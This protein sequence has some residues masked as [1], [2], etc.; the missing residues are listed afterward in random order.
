MTVYGYKMLRSDYTSLREEG[1]VQYDPDGGWVTVPGH[2]AYVAV[3]GG[4][5]ADG[6][7]PVIVRMECRSQVPHNEFGLPYGVQCFRRVRIVHVLEP[8]EPVVWPDGLQEWYYDG[9]LHHTTGPAVIYAD[10]TQEWYYGNLLHR[11]DGPAVIR[12]DGTKEWYRRGVLHRADGPAVIRPDGTKEWHR[13][14]A[15]HRAGG[16]ALVLADGTR[17]WYYDGVP[18]RDG[19][20]AVE[21]P[22]GTKEWW[23]QGER[24]R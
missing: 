9:L 11:E 8:G 1:R 18:H 7:G 4:L 3:E 10:G 14:G 24:V 21:H 19:G 17:E 23:R 15:L 12:P 20:P 16:P 22:D 6:R 2:G 5:T 13:A